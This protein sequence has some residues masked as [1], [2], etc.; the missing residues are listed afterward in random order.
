MAA[1]TSA[2]AE[3]PNQ[4]FDTILLL[5]FGSQTSHLILRCLRSLNIYAEMLP[6]TTKIADLT[7]KPK[8]VILSGGPA[9]VY[10]EAAPHADPAVFDLGVPILGICYGCQEIAWRANSAN[11]AAGEAREYGH[12]DVTIKKVEGADHVNK[13]FQGLGEE[14]HVYMSHFDKLVKLPEGFTILAS[15][16]NSEFAGI[17]HETKPVFGVQ[18]H[19]E[20]EHTPRGVELFKNFAVDICGARQ[21][22]VMSDFIQHEIQRI[23]KLVGPKAQV[24]GAVSGGVDSTVAARL[25]T[26][27]IG[28]RFHA[29]L[30]DNGV[31]R[32][33]EC[34]QVKETLEKHLGINLTVIDGADL[35]LSRLKGL[36]EPE[37]KRKVIGSTF[38]DLFEE[39]AIRIEK[40]AENTPNAGKVEY[41]L[42][43]TLYPDVIESLSFKGPSATIKTHHNVGGLPARMMNGQGLK[44]IEPLREL[45]KDEVREFGR[46]LGIH[47]DL[48]MRHP[49]PGPGIAIRIIGEVTP[50]RVAIARKADHIFISM[51]REAGIYNEMSQAYAGLDTNRAVGVMGD[52]RVYGY[53]IILRAVTTTNFMTAEPYE[54]KFDLLKKIARRIVNEVDGVARVTYDITS[55]PPGTIELE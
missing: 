49:F 8:G 38:I 44:L 20:V 26:E 31:M 34:Q 35:F 6:C 47:E 52:A 1:A 23:R 32:L 18:F 51:I 37:A 21:H 55:K 39:E 15:T 45:F 40:A 42:Q 30:V 50:E 4:T 24:I 48:V 11:V 9:S 2:E 54:F 28:D 33:N 7:W 19:P 5:D 22:W 16:P 53:I 27:A 14:M 43:G 10:D 25:M 46:Q 17:A 13:L 3:A 29:V 12:A 36:T 41:F